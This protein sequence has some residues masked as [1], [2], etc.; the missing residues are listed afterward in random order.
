[1]SGSA[2]SK[3]HGEKR[4]AGR[5]YLI[6]G[7][8]GGLGRALSLVFAREGATVVLLDR[9]M[10]D[11]EAVY[12]D[13][14]AAGGPEPAI[15]A[16]DLEGAQA[17]DYGKL[18]KALEG[19]LGGIDGIIHAAARLGPLTPVEHY[20]AEEWSGLMRG[21]VTGP[22]LLTQAC[23]ELLRSSE[24]PT[25]TFVTDAVGAEPTAYW[26]AYAVSKAAVEA[27]ARV[28]AEENDRGVL[29]VNTIEPGPIRTGLQNEAYPAGSPDDR[30][31][32]G[33]LAP[34]FVELVAPVGRACHGQR[35]R[36]KELLI[37]GGGNSVS[38]W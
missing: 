38:G 14:E 32:P 35:V 27:L 15:F 24:D 16:L 19:E 22:F 9:S 13:I 7:A 21:H 36:A 3:N 8:A 20:P 30:R 28:M 1:M 11:L 17:A 23:L 6:T 5:V 26:G 31:D 33:E 12:D 25:V 4:L 2:G 18:A 34:A 10:P 29:R 37:G